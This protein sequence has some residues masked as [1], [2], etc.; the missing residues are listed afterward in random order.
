VE[1]KNEKYGIRRIKILRGY[2]E[3][4]GEEEG[5]IWEWRD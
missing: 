4:K 1:V 2:R 5:K 3:T